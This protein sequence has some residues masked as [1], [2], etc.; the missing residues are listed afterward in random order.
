MSVSP[1]GAV[2][3]RSNEL[4]CRSCGGRQEVDPQAT[5]YRCT[6]C[7]AE[8]RWAACCG[9]GRFHLLE[10]GA[11]SWSCR[12]CHA[13]NRS[14]WRTSTARRDEREV[15]ARRLA[16]MA[17]RRRRAT[18]CRRRSLTVIAV[19]VVMVILAGV[20]ATLAAGPASDPTRRA[21][22]AY[23]RLRPTLFN[24]SVAGEE[25]R[26]QVASLAR[27][28]AGADGDVASAAHRLANSGPLGGPPF[29]GALV[30]LGDAC[31]RTHG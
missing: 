13:A 25:L 21:C 24:G 28:G 22:A 16:G 5:G 14:W 6:L 17:E 20:L 1:A 27:E 15:A 31:R 23:E 12:G 10:D 9:C 29:E 3:R 2:A 19:T 11:E 7:A 18:E 8:W 26:R 4:S 30:E